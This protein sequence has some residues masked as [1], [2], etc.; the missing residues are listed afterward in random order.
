MVLSEEGRV[1]TEMEKRIM[2]SR[3]GVSK[4]FLRVEKWN[5]FLRWTSLQ[6]SSF[7][8]AAPP[9]HCTPLVGLAS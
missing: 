1:E 6:P 8:S 5:R 7:S 4:A 3:I 9:W 2:Y